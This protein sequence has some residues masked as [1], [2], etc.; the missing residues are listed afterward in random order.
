VL[1]GKSNDVFSNKVITVK[2]TNPIDALSFSPSMI[3]SDP[4]IFHV[5]LQPSGTLL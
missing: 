1:R 2:L 3:V 4:D 5:N